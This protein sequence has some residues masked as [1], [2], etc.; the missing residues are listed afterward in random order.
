[1]QRALGVG[2]AHR[3]GDMVVELAVVAAVETVIQVV[4]D[5]VA[6]VGLAHHAGDR[7]HGRRADEAARLGNLLHRGGQLGQGLADR[8]AET[9]DVEL[10]AVIVHREAAADIQHPGLEP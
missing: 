5:L 2:G 4:P 1:M 9:V 10:A 8:G 6:A 3:V 7:G